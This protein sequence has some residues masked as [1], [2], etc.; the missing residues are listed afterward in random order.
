MLFPPSGKGR[1]R[2][3]RGEKGRF[4]PISTTG[5]QTPLNPICYT[6]IC[7]TPRSFPNQLGNVFVASGNVFEEQADGIGGAPLQ[8]TLITMIDG[9]DKYEMPAQKLDNQR[10]S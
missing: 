5:G 7:L 3:K 4:R 8:L 6:P 1:K 2:Q 9:A 10:D